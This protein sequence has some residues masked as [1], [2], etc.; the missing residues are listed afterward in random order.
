VREYVNQ[1]DIYTGTYTPAV[2]DEV[3]IDSLTM[4]EA[5]FIRIGNNITVHGKFN[6]D[7][8]TANTLASFEID[9]PE[10]SNLTSDGD[11]G[12]SGNAISSYFGNLQDSNTTI[13]GSTATN[14]AKFAIASSVNT[15]LGCVFSFNYT[16]K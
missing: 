11:L 3:N 6:I 9:L 15:G 5:R 7:V 4:N 10:P 14:T 13:Y 12:G 1:G 16:I 2:S 8:T